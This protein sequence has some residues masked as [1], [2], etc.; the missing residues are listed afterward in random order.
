VTGL[1]PVI[2]H[3]L[4]C[5]G[6]TRDLDLWSQLAVQYGDPILDVGAGTGRVTLELA[7]AGHELVALDVDSALL[8]ELQRRADGLALR[9]VCADARQFEL[10]ERFALCLVPM[11]TIQLLG[12][13]A[14]RRS[15][16][17]CVRRHL[18]H[19]GVL[20][21]ALTD[22]LEPFEVL[23]GEPAP[24]PDIREHD[25]V[26]Y[27]SQPTAVRLE[28]GRCVLER[29]REWV[30]PD[31]HHEVCH[32]AVALDL[33]SS[34]ELIV[35]AREAGLQELGVRHVPSTEEHTGSEVVLLGV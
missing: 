23:D 4:E 33:V 24:L 13:A 9:T 7:R 2:W 27:C 25:G 8:G 34:A 11:Q 17:L 21:V 30:D 1:S 22:R 5:G 29:R 3:D 10:G 20:A 35:E 12:G 6:Y 16:L 31:G 26:V 15:F 28:A 18:Q 14:G 32:N 19:G